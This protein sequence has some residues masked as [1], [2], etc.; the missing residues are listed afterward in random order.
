MTEREVGLKQ[1][2]EKIG[3][4]RAESED[5]SPGIFGRRF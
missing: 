3:G 4:F 5:A 1:W 2:L